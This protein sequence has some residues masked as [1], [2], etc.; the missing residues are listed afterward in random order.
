VLPMLAAFGLRTSEIHRL[1]WNEI[2]LVCGEIDIPS[3]KSKAAPADLSRY[4]QTSPNGSG[5]IP[6]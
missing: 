4:W 3:T 2:D 6:A 1:H 5:R